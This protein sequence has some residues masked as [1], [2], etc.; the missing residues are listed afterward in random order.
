MNSLL[1]TLAPGITAK[2]NLLAV[3]V[4][5]LDGRLFEDTHEDIDRRR[6][7][8]VAEGTARERG[9]PSPSAA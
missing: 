3:L 5:P 7:A 2:L 9:R 6:V 8:R 4:R 1:G